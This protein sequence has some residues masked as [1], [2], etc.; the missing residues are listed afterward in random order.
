[1]KII[2]VS[3]IEEIEVKKQEIASKIIEYQ[4]AQTYQL[5][6]GGPGPVA[7]YEIMEIVNEHNGKFEVVVKE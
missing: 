1:M 3:L 7:D 4:A 6:N 5:Q 2:K